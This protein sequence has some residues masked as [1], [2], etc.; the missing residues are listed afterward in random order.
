MLM[1]QAGEGTPV[2]LLRGL[3]LPDADGSAADLI[4]SREIDL[5]R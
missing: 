2:A 4:R 3:D 1:G 5:F